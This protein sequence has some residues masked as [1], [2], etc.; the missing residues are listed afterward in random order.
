M[1][2]AS[3]DSFLLP[4]LLELSKLQPRQQGFHDRA[5]LALLPVRAF[6]VA[7]AAGAVAAHALLVEHSRTAGSIADVDRVG[8][9]ADLGRNDFQ[10]GG[11]LRGERFVNGKKPAHGDAFAV[12]CG[13]DITAP[14]HPGRAARHRKCGLQRRQR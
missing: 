8:R 5:R 1:L 9:A 6:Q 4:P 2:G 7:G 11:V 3:F 12:A 10:H 14:S 13:Q